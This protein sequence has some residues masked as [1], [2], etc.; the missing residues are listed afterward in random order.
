MICIQ[1]GWSDQKQRKARQ[2]RTEISGDRIWS[3][4]KFQ[5]HQRA[6]APRDVSQ[7]FCPVSGRE[8]QLTMTDAFPV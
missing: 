8:R 5:G 1:L 7:L 3:G 4:D 2:K 6:P